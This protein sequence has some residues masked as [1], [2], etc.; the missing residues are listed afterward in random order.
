MMK[1][2]QLPDEESAP[3]EDMRGKKINKGDILDRLLYKVK[4]E[5]EI[6]HVLLHYCKQYEEM[7][8]V[9]IVIPKD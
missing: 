2:Y 5:D 9:T 8:D 1:L 4:A 7:L 6:H 3:T